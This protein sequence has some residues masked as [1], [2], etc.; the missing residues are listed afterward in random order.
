MPIHN[1]KNE[2]N[3]Q[4]ASRTFSGDTQKSVEL[5]AQDE[6]AEAAGGSA[7]S[8]ETDIFLDEEADVIKISEYLFYNNFIHGTQSN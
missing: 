5:D 8:S 3:T 2:S 7:T 6:A 1:A 4:S